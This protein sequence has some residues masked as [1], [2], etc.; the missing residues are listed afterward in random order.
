MGGYVATVGNYSIYYGDYQWDYVKRNKPKEYYQNYSFDAELSDNK[1]GEATEIKI[2]FLILAD[3]RL[4]KKYYDFKWKKGNPLHKFLYDHVKN[5]GEKIKA[6]IKIDTHYN[7][8]NYE[9][10]DW[11][12]YYTSSYYLRSPLGQEGTVRLSTTPK[13]YEIKSYD[14]FQWLEKHGLRT[15]FKK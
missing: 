4:L 7:R 10:E 11:E 14:D 13:R 15:D 12:E 1:T 9:R 3:I 5:K 8:I 2:P 6:Y